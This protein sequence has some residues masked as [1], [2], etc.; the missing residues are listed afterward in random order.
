[1]KGVSTTQEIIQNKRKGSPRIT[2]STLFTSGR[3]KTKV[4]KGIA[5]RIKAYIVPFCIETSFP[6]ARSLYQKKKGEKTE[7]DVTYLGN[8]PLELRKQLLSS[9]YKAYNNM[10]D[11]ENRK[12]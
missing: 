9:N 2:G 12:F 11:V 1:M 8:F 3:A 5:P 7:R 4:I 10:P 6:R